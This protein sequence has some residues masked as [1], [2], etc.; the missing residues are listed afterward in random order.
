MNNNSTKNR[1]DTLFVE[2]L[3]KHAP[4][5]DDVP[6]QRTIN[7]ERRILDLVASDRER[8][9]LQTAMKAVIRW[10]SS[11]IN[12]AIPL[13]GLGAVIA[14]F[15]LFIHER[16]LSTPISVSFDNSEIESYVEDNWNQLLS[17]NDASSW[18][19]EV[20]EMLNRY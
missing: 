6:S 19:S 1:D 4:S 14:L 16:D 10:R 13:V 2:F 9:F 12:I 5:I 18:G 15:L 3:K 8:S 17:E 20:D 11:R 7:L